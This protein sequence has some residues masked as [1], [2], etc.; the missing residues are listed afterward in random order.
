MDNNP[1]VIMESEKPFTFIAFC[2]W[3][4]FTRMK[5]LKQIF[6]RSSVF[7]GIPIL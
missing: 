1:V 4:A 3:N 5:G 7:K 2:T 6:G